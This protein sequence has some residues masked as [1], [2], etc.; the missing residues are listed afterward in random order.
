MFGASGGL[1]STVFL[2]SA[3]SSAGPKKAPAMA[4][5]DWSI[6]R[7]IALFQVRLCLN[8]FLASCCFL[9]RTC[10]SSPR[11]VLLFLDCLPTLPLSGGR[12]RARTGKKRSNPFSLSTGSQR[13]PAVCPR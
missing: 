12:P 7:E 9:S 6:E 2:F 5:F 3:A 4:F 8:F 1:V 11:A 10:C 13:Q